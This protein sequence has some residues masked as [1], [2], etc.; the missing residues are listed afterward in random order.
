MNHKFAVFYVSV[1]SV[2]LASSLFANYVYWRNHAV[3]TFPPEVQK[4][5]IN[6]TAVMEVWWRWTPETLEMV[7]KVNDDDFDIIE[8]EPADLLRPIYA[9][10]DFLSLLF[11]SDNSGNLSIPS[12]DLDED[13][14]GVFIYGLNRSIVL[15]HC[16][17]DSYKLVWFPS[18]MCGFPTESNPTKNLNNTYFVYKEDEGYMFCISIPLELMNVTVPTPV[19]IVFHDGD[20]PKWLDEH[21][22]NVTEYDEEQGKASL[23]AELWM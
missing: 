14:H 10:R 11:D 6:R 12:P 5:V 18:G 13:D 15:K 8:A 2:V 16:Y 3:F 22:E 20:Y 4:V 21:R 1:V 19:Y 23:A 9:T 17:I 7:V